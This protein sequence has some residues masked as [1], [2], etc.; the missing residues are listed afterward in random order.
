MHLIIFIMYIL[1]I[2]ARYIFLDYNLFYFIL[3]YP[4][5]TLVALV[6]KNVTFDLVNIR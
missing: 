1:D 2:L 3:L 6:R 5:A 4:R